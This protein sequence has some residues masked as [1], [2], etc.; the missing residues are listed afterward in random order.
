MK[1]TVPIKSP[2]VVLL[3]SALLGLVGC[4]NSLVVEGKFPPPHVDK[5]PLTMGV[6]YPDEF[7]RY[8]Y[9]E[10]S[11]DRSKWVIASGDAQVQLFSTVLSSM[12]EQ[13]VV[14]ETIPPESPEN[15]PDLILSPS[16][17]EFQ[18]AVPRETKVNV[19]EVWIKF[20]LR[21]YDQ[22]GELVADW[23]LPAYGKTPSAFLKSKE[24]AMNEAVV[25]ALRDIGA[26]LSLGFSHVPE[27]KAW[28]EQQQQK[29]GRQV[30]NNKIHLTKYF[31]LV[32]K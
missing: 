4:T 30:K 25:V 14:V 18:Y 12:F 26:S 16:I 31:T 7:R 9:K 24:E 17:N 20:N 8:T 28:L 1:T 10:E 2:T 29:S 11:S 5:V 27:I 21:V 6:L 15:P 22:E 19:F 13:L 32:V 23:I 3:V